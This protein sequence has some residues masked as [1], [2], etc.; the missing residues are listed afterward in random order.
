M[1]LTVLMF[2]V[3]K[4]SLELVYLKKRISK[5]SLLKKN[6]MWG[7]KKNTYS[8]ISFVLAC[9]ALMSFFFIIIIVDYLDVFV[10]SKMWFFFLLKKKVKI[11]SAKFQRYFL[12]RASVCLWEVIW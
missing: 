12:P 9:K 8:R 6:F 11:Y 2:F 7:E 10:F 4:T 3:D 5:K 1:S